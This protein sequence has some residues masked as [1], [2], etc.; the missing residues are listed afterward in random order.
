MEGQPVPSSARRTA[1][2]TSRLQPV[3]GALA[4]GTMLLASGCDRRGSAPAESAAVTS[5]PPRPPAPPPPP[6]PFSADDARAALAVLDAAPEQ[7]FPASRF[8]TAGLVGRLAAADTAEQAGAQRQLRAEVLDYARAQHGLTIPVGALPRAWNQ[9]PSHY[10]ADAEL[11]GALRTHTL[12]AWLD[13][14]P[15]ATPAYRALQA[16]YA[17]A[18]AGHADRDRPRVTAGALELGQTDARSHALRQRL[19]SVGADLDEDDPDAPV[20]Q[21]L[22]DAL[23]DYQSR[24]HLEETSELDEATVA[25]LNAPVLGRAARLRIN[26]ERLRWLPRPEPTERIDVDIAGGELTYYRGGEPVVHMLAVSG[27]PGDETPIVSSAIDSLVLNPPWNV[28]TDIA[29]R[30][31]LPKGA[32]YLRARHFAWRGGRLVQQAGPKTALGLVKFNF[33]NPYAVYLHDTPSK[34]SFALAQRTASHGCVRVQ[35]AVE[36]A[37]TVAEDEPG[38]SPARV[39][40]VLASGRTGWLKLA[41]PV[42]VRLMY[43]TARPGADGIVYGPDVYSWD[44]VLLGLLDRYS[45]RRQ[46]P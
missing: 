42:P 29:R 1:W 19:K 44:P 34:A 33:P 36:L 30:E 37:R 25:A 24:H 9:R 31:I 10:D 21:D 14:L 7:G 40:K 41:R 12:Q 39:D 2:K 22:L 16:A 46:R 20:D 8:Q 18:I 3:V 15:P 45:T 38:L 35:H 11:D 17:A 13:G 27:K 26:L 32:G 23:G 43:L 6:P 5:P 4:I 28:P